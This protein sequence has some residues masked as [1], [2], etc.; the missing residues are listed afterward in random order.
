MNSKMDTSTQST[1]YD[2]LFNEGVKQ[3]RLRNPCNVRM[4]DGEMRCNGD[5]KSCCFG[6]EHLTPNGCGVEALSCKLWLC[7]EVSQLPANRDIVVA[8]NALKSVGRA[9]GLPVDTNWRGFR[10][11][12]EQVFAGLVK[13][14]DNIHREIVI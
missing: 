7:D 13:C 10:K 11:S 6:C 3:L 8:L 1:M 4:E 2:T 14:K 12:K 5:L 9:V